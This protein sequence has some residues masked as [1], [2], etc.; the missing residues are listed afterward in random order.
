[1]IRSRSAAVRLAGVGTLVLALG[2]A[3][4]STG[5]QRSWPEASTPPSERVST[6]RVRVVNASKPTRCAEEDNVYVKLL[7]PG[8]TA[9]RISAEHPPYI[10]LVREDS[11][12][13]DFT[14]CDMSNDPAFAFQARQVTLYEDA[15]IRLVGH[16]FPSFW[17]PEV[18]GFRVG[19]VNEPG[20]HLVQLIR[21]G[22]KHDVEILVVYPSDG[23]WR[24][25]PLP[26]STLDDTA[27]GSSFLFGP[28]DED[29]RPFVAI[30]EI[31]FEPETLTFRLVFR[32][33]TRG[34]L[35]VSEVTRARLGLSLSVDTPVRADQPFAA[36]RSMYVN[37]V[38][39]DVAVAAWPGRRPGQVTSAPVMDFGT[40]KAS[41]VRF[42][43]SLPSWHN[44][45]A[46]DMVFDGF[47]A[48]ARY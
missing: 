23:Y 41:S 3:G 15:S 33:G 32:N 30:R 20:L 37:P 26:P 13:P 27:Y 29:G 14:D 11:T 28:I 39:A 10:A 35:T 31:S 38:Q 25:K 8:I 19:A 44:L 46:P 40:V 7:A 22:P 4:C 21:R 18:V 34:T 24:A 16:T 5:A 17:R 43:R 9:F 47:S 36:L 42:G 1:M 2:L 48:V 6:K 45:S 12:A